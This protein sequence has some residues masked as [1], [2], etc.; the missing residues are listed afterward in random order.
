LVAIVA[1]AGPGVSGV[2]MVAQ[3]GPAA[4]VERKPPDFRIVEVLGVELAFTGL[5]LERAL[6]RGSSLPRGM[7]KGR[8]E[9][10]APFENDGMGNADEPGGSI[11]DGRLDRAS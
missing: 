9:I 5:T 11:A 7:K 6:G 2:A 4:P 3:G 10:G 1:A 8:A